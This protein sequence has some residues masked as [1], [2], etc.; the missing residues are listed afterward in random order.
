MC[1]QMETARNIALHI[2]QTAAQATIQAL[3]QLRRKTDGGRFFAGI[4]EAI[5]EDPALT[6]S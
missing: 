3:L 6:Q 1:R 5:K 4:R 2:T